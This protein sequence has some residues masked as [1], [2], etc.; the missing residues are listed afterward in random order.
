MSNNLISPFFCSGIDVPK[1]AKPRDYATEYDAYVTAA[2]TADVP[3]NVAV[4]RKPARTDV[5]AFQPG[6][7]LATQP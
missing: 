6:H 3:A 7:Q 4:G 1:P 5:D 2:A